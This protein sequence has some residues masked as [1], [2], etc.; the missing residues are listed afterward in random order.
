[1]R[2]VTFVGVRMIL[3]GILFVAVMGLLVTTLWNQLMPG[4]FGLPVINIWQALGLFLL[5]RLLFGRF[6]GGRGWGSRFRK[7]RFAQGW[8]NLTPEERARFRSAMGAR[9]GAKFGEG[10]AAERV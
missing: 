5:S 6:G 9:C 1:M 7:G 8:K 2:R 4:I 10:E 3:F